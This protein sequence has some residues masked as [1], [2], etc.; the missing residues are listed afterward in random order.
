M[1][2]YYAGHRGS[3]LHLFEPYISLASKYYEKQCTR[4][5]AALY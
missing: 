1:Q 2:F 4:S 3:S 5:K